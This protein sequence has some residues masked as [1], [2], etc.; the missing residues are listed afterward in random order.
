MES[1]SEIEFHGNA[2]LLSNFVCSQ[3][4]FPL[5][6]HEYSLRVSL[7]LEIQGPRRFPT[8][9]VDNEIGNVVSRVNSVRWQRVRKADNE[10]S[11]G[12]ERVNYRQTTDA[13]YIGHWSINDRMECE[14][15]R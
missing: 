5:K 3:I 12:I 6:R 7:S 2:R 11:I 10:N 4:L 9:V 15:S 8:T 1:A 13:W 14:K